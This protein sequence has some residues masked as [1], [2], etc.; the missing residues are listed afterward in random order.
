MFWTVF[1]ANVLLGVCS[2]GLSILMA[3]AFAAWR[4]RAGKKSV[5]IQKLEGPRVLV[6][7]GAAP[8]P[9][10]CPLCGREWPLPGPGLREPPPELG[11]SE[12]R[13]SP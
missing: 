2:V 1:K 8:R 9:C 3:L 7:G 4:K 6:L 13:G 10:A 12:G 5:S 11:P